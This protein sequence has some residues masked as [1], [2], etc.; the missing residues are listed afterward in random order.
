MILK[1]PQKIALKTASQT[2][3]FQCVMRLYFDNLKKFCFKENY[4][5]KHFI[6][7]FILLNVFPLK[8]LKHKI[9]F[10]RFPCN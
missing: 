9:T 1:L 8:N 5:I 3:M 10:I 4:S 6:N 7:K 2:V